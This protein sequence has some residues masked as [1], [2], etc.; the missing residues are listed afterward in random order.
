[1]ESVRQAAEREREREREREEKGLQ[2]YNGRIEIEG[3][4]KRKLS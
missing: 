4:G 3:K 1:M 2:Y